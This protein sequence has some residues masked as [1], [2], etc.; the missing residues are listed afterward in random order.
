MKSFGVK[1]DTCAPRLDLNR[2]VSKDV[3][4]QIPESPLKSFCEKVFFPIPRGVTIPTPVT[5][6]FLLIDDTL[7]SKSSKDDG[8]VVAAKGKGIGKNDRDIRFS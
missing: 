4:G 6:T 8:R 3:I 7:F 5:T 2:D 1:S